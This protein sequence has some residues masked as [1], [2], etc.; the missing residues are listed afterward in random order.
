MAAFRVAES[1]EQRQI[2][3]DNQRTRQGVLRAAETPEQRQIRLDDQRGRQAASR[4]AENPEHRRARLDDQCTRQ[5]VSRTA[6]NSKQ[7]QTRLDNKRTRQAASRAAETPD[8][9]RARSEDQ[10]TRQAVL[11]A[12]RWTVLEDTAFQY[13][14]ANNYDNYLQLNVGR[15]DNVYSYRGALKW[16]GEAP[17]MCCSGGKVKL[18]ALRPPPEPLESLM[19]GTTFRSKHFLENIRKHNSCFQMTSFGATNEVCESGF[20]PTFKVQGQ[21]HHCV[22]S[23]LLLSNEKHQFLQIYFM[24][25][26]QKEA[27]QRCNNIPDTRQHIVL[28]LQQT[29]HHYNNY[30]RIFKNALQKMPSDQ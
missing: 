12:A 13:N 11:R 30:V 8:Q 6:E 20:M 1:P 7:R 21:V 5:V 16:N 29:L 23:L 28:K 9:R 18:P 25:D 15:M 4:I 26:G 19:S 10:R 24:G 27:K 17:G 22:G 2:R 14:P 3:L